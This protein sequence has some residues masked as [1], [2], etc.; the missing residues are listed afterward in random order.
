MVTYDDSE[1]LDLVCKFYR[2]LVYAVAAAAL[3]AA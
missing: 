3:A 1:S 2:N